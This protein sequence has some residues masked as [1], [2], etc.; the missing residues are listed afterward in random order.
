MPQSRTLTTHSSPTSSH[1]QLRD[2]DSTCSRFATKGY[3]ASLNAIDGGV[4][5]CQYHHS[6]KFCFSG[7]SR[8]W[9]TLSPS[10][11]SQIYSASSRQLLWHGLMPSVWTVNSVGE[12]SFISTEGIRRIIPTNNYKTSAQKKEAAQHVIDIQKDLDALLKII[13]CK[14]RPLTPT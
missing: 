8:R 4:D 1:V 6:L 7:W 10:V 9:L 14:P 11:F 13:P 12:S 5:K 2:A 3:V